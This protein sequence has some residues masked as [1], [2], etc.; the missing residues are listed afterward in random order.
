MGDGHGV[1]FADHPFGSDRENPVQVLASASAKRRALDCRRHRELLIELGDV[2]LA[3]KAIGVLQCDDPGQAQFL[4]Q[5][6]LP[7]SEAAFATSAGLRR[8]RS[9]R[10]NA[11]F[12]QRPAELRGPTLVD[13]FASLGNVEKMAAPIAIKRAALSARSLPALRSSLCASILPP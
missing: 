2:T 5:P 12:F 13:R 6:P 8:I 7:G 4:R 3:Q 9:N 1:I 11:E 10:L